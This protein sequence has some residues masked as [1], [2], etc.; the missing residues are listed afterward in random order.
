MQKSSL[1]NATRVVSLLVAVLLFT[2]C[3]GAERLDRRDSRDA[4]I[5]RGDARKRAGDIDG[6]IKLYHQAL[7]RRPQL[8]LAHLKLAVEYDQQ[9]GDYLRAIHHYSRYQEKRPNAEKY[10]LIN[11]FIRTARNSYLATLP[12]PPPGAIEQIAM[13]KRE[14]EELIYQ[15]EGLTER[16]RAMQAEQHAAAPPRAR[17]REQTRAPATP[18]RRA[19]APTEEDGRN[20]K[21]RIY[22][23]QRGDTLSAIAGR[24][25]EDSGQ[26][27][28]IYEANRD[29]LPTPE[30]LREGQKLVIPQ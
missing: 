13:L 29:Q 22:E 21:E 15:I 19:P 30:N 26:W 10:E 1:Q 23:V 6:A 28:R 5:M 20:G 2:A 12:D 7:E 9:K 4:L 14:N 11:E 17:E 3:G 8:A 25:Y 27:R 16:V 18:A 24:V